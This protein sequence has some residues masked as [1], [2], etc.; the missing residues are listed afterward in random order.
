MTMSKRAS[1]SGEV[2]VRARMLYVCR[3]VPC[4]HVDQAKVREDAELIVEEVS[5]VG[6]ARG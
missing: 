1:A 3:N 2:L 4:I 6:T 5:S